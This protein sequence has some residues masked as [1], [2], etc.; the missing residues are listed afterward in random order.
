L[1]ETNQASRLASCGGALVDGG[2][3]KAAARRN[4]TATAMTMQAQNAILSHK[5]K[6]G[7]K[8]ALRLGSA[9]IAVEG[10]ARPLSEAIS[11]SIPS[12]PG[13]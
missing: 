3:S 8:A 5:G 12:F 6:P 1:C 10:C 9:L 13:L 11:I 7:G 2:S 4:T